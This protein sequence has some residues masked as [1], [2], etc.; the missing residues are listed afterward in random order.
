MAGLG[1]K[2]MALVQQSPRGLTES[3]T[4]FFHEEGYLVVEDLFTEADLQPA[5]DDINRAI[6]AKVGRVVGRRACCRGATP[7]SISNI[8]WPR[9]AARPTR[10]PSSLWNGVLH[11]PGFFRIDHQPET[12]R[13]GRV[14]LRRGT[15]RIERLPL[16]AQDSQLQLRRRALAPGL[17]LL[18]AVLR[19]VRSC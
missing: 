10:S 1:E 5:I 16:A 11:G 7:S 12:A 13:R 9:S 6:D 2:L 14:A 18:R 15:D 8:A 3:Q 4:A 17:G 19:Q